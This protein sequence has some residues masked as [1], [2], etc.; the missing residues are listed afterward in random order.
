M[1]LEAAAAL[2]LLLCL[3]SMVCILPLLQGARGGL[4]LTPSTATGRLFTAGSQQC[5][6]SAPAGNPSHP[7]AAPA[8]SG[9]GVGQVA[10]GCALALLAG[11][12][13][14][15]LRMLHERMA[16]HPFP[17]KWAHAGAPTSTSHHPT[18]LSSASKDSQAASDAYGAVHEGQQAPGGQPPQLQGSLFSV[19]SSSPSCTT[20]VCHLPAAAAAQKDES[21]E[22]QGMCNVGGPMSRAGSTSCPV[23]PRLALGSHGFLL[24]QHNAIS[25]PQS[26]RTSADS[27]SGAHSISGISPRAN[28]RGKRGSQ[29][30]ELGRMSSGQ[31][32]QGS[33]AQDSGSSSAAAATPA[34]AVA[35]VREA[36]EER[37]HHGQLQHP[38]PLAPRRGSSSEDERFMV[39]GDGRAMGG[40]ERAMQQGDGRAARGA[41]RAKQQGGA[42]ATRGNERSMPQAEG[43][44]ARGAEQSMQ[45]RMGTHGVRQDLPRP[46][47]STRPA[48]AVA[49]VA[50][51]PSAAAAGAPSMQERPRAGEPATSDG[52][53]GVASGFGAASSMVSPCGGVTPDQFSP[54]PRA[55][56]AHQSFDQGHHHYNQ[57]HQ[58]TCGSSTVMGIRTTLDSSTTAEPHSTW[59]PPGTA[60]GHPVAT[61]PSMHA[62][63]AAHA[64]HASM[65]GT[66]P[67]QPAV[68]QPCGQQYMGATAGSLPPS[69]LTSSTTF[70]SS[71]T[72][73]FSSTSQ[74]LIMNPA[75]G[76]APATSSAQP[77]QAAASS[78]QS[79]RARVSPFRLAAMSRA[80][81]QVGGTL[82]STSAPLPGAIAAVNPRSGV[83]SGVGM[84]EARADFSCG[85]VPA[86]DDHSMAL[87][88]HDAHGAAQP[89]LAAMQAAAM[90]R[91]TCDTRQ[92]RP[93][94]VPRAGSA[95]MLRHSSASNDHLLDLSTSPAQGAS[96]PEPNIPP[97]TQQSQSDSMSTASAL[98]SST[99]S[100]QGPLPTFPSGALSTTSLPSSGNLN[101]SHPGS[102]GASTLL[103]SCSSSAFALCASLAPSLESTGAAVGAPAALSVTGGMY[104][105]DTLT[106]DLA[107]FRAGSGA[108][109]GVSTISGTAAVAG[110]KEDERAT[111]TATG[112]PPVAG[113]PAPTPYPASANASISRLS[114]EPPKPRTAAMPP[115]LPTPLAPLSAPPAIVSRAVQAVQMGQQAV[116]LPS[117]SHSGNLP[118]SLTY[119]ARTRMSCVSV[120]VCIAD[121]LLYLIG[122]AALLSY[123]KVMI[124]QRC[125]A[126]AA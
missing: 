125:A 38:H 58:G 29:L 107:V 46:A 63:H 100:L 36:R 60:A 121:M 27:F 106:S 90:Q 44:A 69:L 9:V 112:L 48:A 73:S 82:C 111:V 40:A 19:G 21:T 26:P 71:T 98:S 96:S 37:S 56:G 39:Q 17:N 102:R 33:L 34:A 42:Q 76:M 126:C 93:P 108:A 13:G 119:K 7:I 62:A 117:G 43:R 23:S 105:I 81:Q 95:A 55:R 77:T 28:S 99:P 32:L 64:A 103:S 120:K 101:P 24:Q 8:G 78:A 97:F 75:A 65:G 20:P 124:Q 89:D 104:L 110:A 54:E 45:P 59:S 52:S 68:Q 4:I 3:E 49:A 122:T 115:P 30:G 74:G 88:M 2:G 6:P 53:K 67:M 83:H 41:E 87:R 109:A 94:S 15:V 1:A 22:E 92:T 72:S 11:A 47:M 118:K 14:A 50:P 18:T 12:A 51:P 35:E 16:P 70:P 5:P 10:L 25:P 114:S 79:G 86:G 123:K 31:L 80:A 91:Q 84:G 57:H 85:D 66:A 61:A 116:R 113:D